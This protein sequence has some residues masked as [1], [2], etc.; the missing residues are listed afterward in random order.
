MKPKN[1]VIDGTGLLDS[2][3]DVSRYTSDLVS[4]IIAREEPY[5]LIIVMF[6]DDK[7]RHTPIASDKVRYVYLPQNRQTYEKLAR[8][9]R[10]FKK[11]DKFIEEKQID[12][13]LYFNSV[14]WPRVKKARRSALFVFDVGF[15]DQQQY[16]PEEEKAA[17]KKLL[18]KSIKKVDVVIAASKFT[19]DRLHEI[20][21]ASTSVEIALPAVDA[22]IFNPEHLQSDDYLKVKYRLPQNFVLYCGDINTRTN[23]HALLSVYSQLP[24]NFRQTF[25][26]V[27][28]GN[29]STHQINELKTKLPELVILDKLGHEDFAPL[30]R[31]ATLFVSLSHY[32]GFGLNALQAMTCGLPIVISSAEG[33]KEVVDGAGMITSNNQ[34][35]QALRAIQGLLSDADLRGEYTARG[36]DRIQAYSWQKTTDT[37]LSI[38]GRPK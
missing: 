16:Y 15:Y 8:G 21:G 20:Y 2:A 24:P 19:A 13:V 9:L 22:G 33:L 31:L 14:A 12:L 34:P 5:K 17:L 37:V 6:E 18:P 29:A 11:I 32:E 3:G 27:M 35:E 7:G 28:A 23:P 38:I 25:G 36:L 10:I 4:E 26:L 30:M 1:I